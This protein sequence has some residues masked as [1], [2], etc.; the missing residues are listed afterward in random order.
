MSICRSVHF[1]VNLV[2]YTKLNSK[3]VLHRNFKLLE[4]KGGNLVTMETGKYFLNMTPKAQS[5]NDKIDK[6]DFIK[7]KSIY[8]LKDTVKNNTSNNVENGRRYLQ[9]I[10][11]IKDLYLEV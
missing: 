8:S 6:W 4:D 10:Y 1:K 11:L 7:M 2:S 3:W 9:I 5:I